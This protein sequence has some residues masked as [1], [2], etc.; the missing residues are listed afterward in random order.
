MPIAGEKPGS[1]SQACIPRDLEAG[2]FFF[3]GLPV[4][5]VDVAV[6]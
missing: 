6:L 1:V 4:E 2:V 5:A 3:C